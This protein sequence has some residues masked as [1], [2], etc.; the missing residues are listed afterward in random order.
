MTRTGAPCGVPHAETASAAAA[1]RARLIR[2]VERML[3]KYRGRHRVDVALSA[4]RG[5]AEL[6]NGAQRRGS[7]ES[8]IEKSHRH[9][10]PLQQLRAHDAHLRAAD[11]LVSR[12]VERDPQQKSLCFQLA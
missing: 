9:S 10:R 5:S 8:L 6:A 2:D 3:Q 11:G 12:S 1:T 7:R 4:P